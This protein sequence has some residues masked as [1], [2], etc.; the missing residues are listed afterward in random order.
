MSDVATLLDARPIRATA[1]DT[2]WDRATTRRDEIAANIRATLAIEKVEALVYVSE[3]GIYPP[4]VTMEAWMP[5]VR[6]DPQSADGRSRARLE[7]VVD[8]RPFH[9]ATL[10]TTL[11]LTR[12]TSTIALEHRPDVTQSDVADWTRCAL[13]AST[14]PRSYTPFKDACVAFVGGLLPFVPVPHQNAIAASYR[15]APAA[16]FKRN[17]ILIVGFVL[18]LIG[19]SL[20][21]TMIGALVVVAAVITKILMGRGATYT[22]YVPEQ[23][24]DV[25]RRIDLVD[26][27]HA[28]VADLGPDQSAIRDRLIGRLSAKQ[29]NDADIVARSETYGYR[30]PNGFEE[31]QRFILRKG[32]ALVY[33]HIYSFGNDMFVG[34]SSYLNRSQWA[35]TK[36]VSSKMEHAKTI[37]FRE[38]RTFQYTPN[39]LD[40]I[41]LNS[42]G[43][44][45][46]R[47]LEIEIKAILKEKKIDQ[48]IDFKIIRGDRGSALDSGAQDDDTKKGKRRGGAKYVEAGA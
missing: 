8:A 37:E 44:F 41:D 21:Y 3:P 38:L 11:R 18:A 5:I 34:W 6:D 26:S 43:E 45:V 1:Q 23:P 42:L 28:V 13:S 12:G 16:W 47:R 2:I 48:E 46:H 7:A 15:M 4:W 20:G 32:Q 10:V 40:M 17:A 30:T 19:A 35:E 31:R 9:R 22:T 24:I 29:K 33:V 39:H 25:P 27:W 14:N 36:P